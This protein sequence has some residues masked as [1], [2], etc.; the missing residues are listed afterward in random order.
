VSDQL[1]LTPRRLSLSFTPKDEGHEHDELTLVRLCSLNRTA[2]VRQ[3]LPA[4]MDQL[5]ASRPEARAAV[6]RGGKNGDR[7]ARGARQPVVENRVAPAGE[8]GQRD[9]EPLEH[10]HQ[11]E[12]QEDGHR[13]SHPQASPARLSSAIGTASA[14]VG[15]SLRGRHRRTRNRGVPHRRSANN[16]APP[17]R[18]RLAGRRRRHRRAATGT[19]QHG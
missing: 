10:A 19:I 17:G 13:S 2:T 15:G 7:S 8:D 4:A 1:A 5:P 6:G 12:A 3:E 11:E 18:N 14:A 16:G 9:Q